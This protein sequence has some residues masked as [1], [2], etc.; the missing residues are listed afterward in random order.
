MGVAGSGKS[1][2][3]PRLADALGVEFV[4]ADDLHTEAARAQIA[5]GRPLSDE[6][7]A[8]WLD[9]LHELLAGRGGRGLV[10]ACSALR[11]SYRRRLTDGLTNVVFVALVAPPAQLEARLESRPDHFAGPEILP[12]QLAALELGDDVVVVD[13]A[14]PVDVVTAAAVRAVAKAGN[15]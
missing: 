4:D 9:R 8:P 11:R 5:S 7:R 12:S 15:A 3:G 1:T 13:C 14:Q 10:L 2:V 6:D